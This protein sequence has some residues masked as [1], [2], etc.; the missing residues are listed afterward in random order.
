MEYFDLFTNTQRELYLEN[1]KLYDIVIPILI[2]AYNLDS[3]SLRIPTMF[4]ALFDKATDVINHYL[5]NKHKYIKDDKKTLKKYIDNLFIHGTVIKKED[6]SINIIEERSDTNFGHINLVNRME[7]PLPKR[8]DT[9]PPIDTT[10]NNYYGKYNYSGGSN[11]SGEHDKKH[12]IYDKNTHIAEEFDANHI[13]PVDG[14]FELYRYSYKTTK[15][16]RSTDKPSLSVS[17]FKP[18]IDTLTGDWGGRYV[19]SQLALVIAYNH[20]FPNGAF[21]IYLD[22]YM[23]DS[24]K[25]FSADKL[26]LEKLSE[27]VFKKSND[28][29]TLFDNKYDI[30]K[31]F[32]RFDDYIESTTHL[33]KFNNA[34]E[35]FMYYYISA[36]KIYR[37]E[38]T[39]EDIENEQGGDFFVYKFKEESDFTE[40]INGKRC[41]ISNGYI[42][43]AMRYICLRQVDYNYNGITIKRNKHFIWRD[44]HTNQIGYNDSQMIQNFNDSVR[45]SESKL[46]NLFPSN[47]KYQTEWHSKAICPADKN[48]YITRSAIAGIVQMTNFTDTSEWLSDKLYYNS[49]G[50]L[51][52]IDKEDKVTLKYHREIGYTNYL[53]K[54]FKDYE[55]GIEEY[56]FNVFFMLEDFKNNN[57]YF[58]DRFIAQAIGIDSNP[59]SAIVGET[60]FTLWFVLWI[61]LKYIKEKENINE[62]TGFEIINKIENLRNDTSVTGT[63][64]KWIQFLLSI[65]PTKYFI[66]NTIFNKPTNESEII[67]TLKKIDLN[68]HLNKLSEKYNIYKKNVLDLSWDDLKEIGINC[69]TPMITSGVE[70]CIQP[71]LENTK[72]CPPEDFFSGFYY[73]QPTAL[74]YGIFR[75]PSE[76]KQLVALI[77]DKKK[78]PLYKNIIIHDLPEIEYRKKYLRYKQKY[79]ELKSKF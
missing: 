29:E 15:P 33:I 71:Y 16:P 58:E 23:L 54:Y 18:N 19:I 22:W 40:I 50:M 53:K 3:F 27:S 12:T 2:V 64:K 67:N 13:H 49:I 48:L 11:Y 75:N 57:I 77:D 36:S 35:K 56:I 59:S 73:D 37:E 17:L 32:K 26:Q 38:Q 47:Y 4:D 42:G 46:F 41:H 63:T 72:D 76:L 55:Y 5:K 79:L 61:L 31:L 60:W 24:F 30:S 43:Q 10:G 25:T 34:F 14:I 69:N 70:W 28:Y 78:I 8:D 68:Y 21:R 7:K 39:N 65:Y 9:L 52:L 6:K 1:Q 51:F 62:L 44:G 45:N 20:Y 74:K 66:A